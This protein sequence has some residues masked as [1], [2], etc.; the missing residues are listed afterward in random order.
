[1]DAPLILLALRA[2]RERIALLVAFS[3]V[4]LAAAVTARVVG[5]HEGHVEFDRLFQIGGYPLISGM[6]LIGWLLGRFGMLA[7]FVMMAGVFSSDRADGT[8][9][10]LYAR[11]MSPLRIYFTRFAVFALAAFA[12][13]A[14]LM[15]LFDLIMLGHWAGPLT[16]VLIG[17]HILTFGSLTFLLS[18]WTRADVWM[19]LL[20]TLIAM[21]WHALRRGDLLGGTAPGI[22]EAITVFLPPH[23]ALLEIEQAFAQ[24]LA[25]P[26]SAVLFVSLYAAL[27]LTAAAVSLLRREV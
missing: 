8:A 1:M 11:P 18:V 19:A 24:S 7:A 25:V 21:V 6:L 20:L 2:R 5:G 16:F 10:L 9:R 12:I 27:L 23:G 13:A 3:A 22:R 4:F 26:W 17:C 15:P 14:V